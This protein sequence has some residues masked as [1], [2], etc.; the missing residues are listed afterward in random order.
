[1]KI[2]EI[3]RNVGGAIISEVV[4]GGGILVDLVN[5]ALPKD[6][7]LPNTATGVEAQ[8]AI[9]SLPDEARADIL[10]RQID[11][12]VETIQQQGLTARAMLETEAVSPQSTRPKIAM[13][14]FRLVSFVTIMVV[15]M[16]AYAVITNKPTMVEAIAVSYTHLTL[17][18][19]A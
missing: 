17:P 14:A 4:P 3:L 9:D 11:L 8:D 15:S 7:Q 18:T 12:K 6:K 10:G 1:M 19:K 16:W 2:G 5:R 13:G